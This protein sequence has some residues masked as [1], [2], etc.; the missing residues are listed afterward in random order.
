[1]SPN[2]L[3]SILLRTHVSIIFPVPQY[4]TFSTILYSPPSPTQLLPS[5]SISLH[6]NIRQSSPFHLHCPCISMSISQ[7]YYLSCLL[8]TFI[9]PIFHYECYPKEMLQKCKPHHVFPWLNI[10][11]LFCIVCRIM[12]KHRN[13]VYKASNEVISAYFFKLNSNYVSTLL[14][15]SNLFNHIIHYTDV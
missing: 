2:L 7:L 9:S 1:M 3:L 6:L 8:I 10:A 11:Q 15:H 4:I 13:V 5:S 14:L 12:C